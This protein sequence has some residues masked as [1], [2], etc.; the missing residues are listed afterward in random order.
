MFSISFLSDWWTR[1]FGLSEVDVHLIGWVRVCL[2][3]AHVYPRSVV[4][5]SF[6]VVLFTLSWPIV[7]PCQLFG[8][9]GSTYHPNK[10]Q[11]FGHW[12]EFGKVKFGYKPSIPS[13]WNV[14]FFFFYSYWNTPCNQGGTAQ[15]RHVVI[16]NELTNEHSLA[17]AAW[18]TTHSASEPALTLN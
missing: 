8:I 13:F 17:T 6:G 10:N 3:L 15:H 7:V 18:I 12:Q 9:R 11:S 5:H 14:L 1:W 16:E 4:D 2:V